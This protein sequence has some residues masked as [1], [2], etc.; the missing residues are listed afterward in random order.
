[1]AT[2]LGDIK[3][4][5]DVD[6]TR[7]EASLN[8]AMARA[9]SA[10]NRMGAGMSSSINQTLS[11]G[12]RAQ[13]QAFS[14][15]L[16]DT[17]RNAFAAAEREQAQSMA[18]LQSRMRQSMGSTSSMTQTGQSVGS[19]FAVGF[20]SPILN[21]ISAIHSAMYG[22]KDIGQMVG[23]VTGF[24][25]AANLG[26]IQSGISAL[27]GSTRQGQEIASQLYDLALNTPFSVEDFSGIGRKMLAMGTPGNQLIS[28][29][30]VLADTVSATG[31]GANELRDMAE[32]IAKVR[33]NP[34]AIDSDTLLGLVR[35][36]MPLRQTA[37]HMAGRRFENEQE[38]TMFLQSRL[39]GRG[40][41]GIDE[42]NQAQRE[43]Y[44][45]SARALGRTDL[46]KVTQRVSESAQGLLMGTSGKGL[47]LVLGGMNLLA[48][49]M[50]VLGKLN[51]SMLGVPG[52]LLLVGAFGYLKNA[53]TTA[54]SSLDQFVAS[55]TGF[56][57]SIQ[58]AQSKNIAGAGLTGLA[59]SVPMYLSSYAQMSGQMNPAFLASHQFVNGQWVQNAPMTP[60]QKVKSGIQGRMN[61]MNVGLNNY[62]TNNPNAI[63]NITSG[64][65]MVGGMVAAQG[66]ANQQIENQGNEKK[67]AESTRL[68]NAL[69]G[70]ASGAM[71]GNL[72]GMSVPVIGNVVGTVVGTLIGGAAGYLTSQDPNNL[73]TK[74][75]DENTK[76]LNNATVAMTL[77]ASSIIGGG[78]RASGAVSAIELEMYMASRNNMMNVGIG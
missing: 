67:L 72:I 75:I 9:T 56:T 66:L 28:Q 31:G 29:M 55:L 69:G 3:I 21:A 62:M 23:T 15:G 45:G 35:S 43:L 16:Q 78:P 13:Y 51:T 39:S 68:Q 52:L 19:S 1:V 25:M 7:F 49:M 60:M 14:T 30:S 74:S 20:S 65:L 54:K 11:A 26:G 12:F 2:E 18:R 77:L 36:G 44:G 48:D 61:A 17:F 42:L 38:A 34:R 53:F 22:L 50:G 10:F 70:A 37:E 41:R 73:P 8:N 4:L 6:V 76:A 27:L 5:I 58:I 47:N 33:M 71:I 59:T 64:L 40:S 32:F 63:G 57:T 24:T 46:S